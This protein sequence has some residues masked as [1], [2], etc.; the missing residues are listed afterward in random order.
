MDF[1]G[2]EF[3]V[4]AELQIP[5][6]DMVS[7]PVVMAALGPRMLEIAGCLTD[8]TVTWMTGPNTLRDH[9]VPRLQ[10]SAAAGN[11]PPRVCVGMP[12]AV[13]D[14][15]DRTRARA[16][17]SSSTTPPFPATA[18]YWNGRGLKA[19]V[20][21]P[22]WAAK[23][24]WRTSCGTW[25]NW[26]PP[27]CWPRSS[28]WTAPRC[29]SPG[30]GPSCRAW[31]AGFNPPGPGRSPLQSPRRRAVWCETQPLI[32]CSAATTACPSRKLLGHGPHALA[33]TSPGRP[34]KETSALPCPLRLSPVR[35]NPARSGGAGCHPPIQ[36]MRRE[37]A[38]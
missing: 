38:A 37:L 10:E 16:N 11:P 21:S 9:V 14:R 19:P 33:S 30:P 2:R 35:Y 34:G 17:R 32:P 15:P 18:P 4:T 29:R 8:G 24:R 25:P 1:Q 3:R 36:S 5:D 31:S 26:A 6:A 13:T 7:C 22:S 20:I 12:V 28:R 23:R 27:T